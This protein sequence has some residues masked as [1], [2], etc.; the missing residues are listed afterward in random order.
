MKETALNKL[1]RRLLVDK[2]VFPEISLY[3]DG[4]LDDINDELLEVEKQQIMTA[5]YDSMGTNTD[6]NMGRAEEYYN[7]TYGKK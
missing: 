6:P 3:I 2:E 4:V 7:E 5:V 1:K